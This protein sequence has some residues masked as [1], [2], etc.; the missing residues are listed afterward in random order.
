MRKQLAL[1]TIILLSSIINAQDQ[2]YVVSCSSTPLLFPK[3]VL[4]KDAKNL[5]IS[6]D[7]SEVIDGNYLLTG[8]ASINSAE[9]YLAADKINLQ[10]A[11]KTSKADGNIKFQGADIMLTGGKATIKKQDSGIHTVFKQVK[12]HYPKGKFNGQAQKIVN[13]GKVQ[14]FDSVSYTLCPVGN[15]DWV[16]KASKMTLN[17]KA[18]K[19]V[20]ENVTVELM[21]VPIFYYP[22]YEWKLKGRSSG[23]LAPTLATFDDSGNDKSGYQIRIPYYFNIAP[24][25]DFLLTLNHVSTRGEAVEGKYRQLL[26]NGRIEIEGHYLN[27]DKISK[28][29]R[30]Y[31]N[32]K[33]DLSLNDKTELNVIG[34]RVSDKQY[35]KEVSHNNT[36]ETSL[37]SSVNLAYKNKEQNLK[38][39]IFAES[40]QLVGDNNDAEYRRAPEISINKKVVGLNGR[41]I[42]FSIIST[43]FKHKTKGANETGIRTHAQATFGRDIKT[44]AYSLQPKFEISKTKYVMDDKTKKDRSIYSFGIDSKLFFERDIGLFGKGVTQILTPR[45]AYNYTP[46]R[47][48][49]ALPNFDSEK[50]SNTYENLFSGKEYTGLDK[51][52]KTNDITLGLESDF[53]D[54]KTGETYLALKIAQAYYLDKKD[55]KDYSN[56]VAGA[57]L[58]IGKFTFNNSLE[59]D[60]QLSEVAKR[61]SAL[62]YI[63]NARKFITLT[64]GDDGE[65]RSAGLYGAYPVTKKIHAFAG[66]N[67]SLSDSINSKK[68]IGVAYESCCWAIRVAQLKEITSGNKFDNVTKFEFVLKGLASSSS[69]LTSR[70]EEDIPNYLGN[71]E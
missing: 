38:A 26:D 46:Y 23:F 53:V 51:I 28:E 60:T 16:M 49:S 10:K 42:N 70:L 22:H 71:L 14:T 68:T 7:H 62:S 13:D 64:Q 15:T 11:T 45:L 9:Y 44:N 63:S 37:I 61:H 48:Q 2:D 33:L 17:P 65:Q 19:G 50:M 40:E 52:S 5:E 29:K 27:K 1:S 32:S 35:F 67:R 55:G 6:A 3:Q 39:S 20:A 18:N 24:E 57:E 4:A 30:W 31:A 25:R 21:G 59:Y 58:T 66:V 41:E 12:F 56:T 69:N 8:N 34:K 47:N 54:Q 43:Q 36:G